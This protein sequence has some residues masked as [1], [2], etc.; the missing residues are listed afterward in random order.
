MDNKGFEQLA[1]DTL[2]SLE[3]TN[4]IEFGLKATITDRVRDLIEFGKKAYE[5]GYKNGMN[6]SKRNPSQ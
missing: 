6:Y 3:K 5:R 1:K 2:A 4:E